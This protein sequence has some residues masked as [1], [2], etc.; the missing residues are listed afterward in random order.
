MKRTLL[1]LSALLFLALTMGSCRRAAENAARKIRIE[2]IEQITPKGLNGADVILRVANGTRHKLVLTKAVFEFY[3]RQ[4]KAMSIRLHESVEIGKRTTESIMT[5]W[6][7][8]I[9]DPLIVLLLG[10]DLETDEPSQI[11]VSYSVEGRGGPASV[12]IAREK[13]PLSDFL[14]T[15]GVTLQDVKNHFQ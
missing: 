11:F 8:R 13:V 12:N 15:F 1:Y 5:R 2:A 7:I 3:Y 6:K 10:R 14:T 4:D 9:D